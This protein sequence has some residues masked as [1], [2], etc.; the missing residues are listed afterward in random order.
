MLVIQVKEANKL[1]KKISQK[2]RRRRL[3]GVPVFTSQ[4]LN[5]AIATVD[6]IKWYV[7]SLFMLMYSL[8]LSLHIY[9]YVYIDMLFGR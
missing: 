8:F 6:G 2:N 9:I 1:L 7:A 5:I 4:N 3:E